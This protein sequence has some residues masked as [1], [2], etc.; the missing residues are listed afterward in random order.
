M[1]LRLETLGP[2][3]VRTLV[4]RVPSEKGNRF[5]IGLLGIT[6]NLKVKY[7]LSRLHT[8]STEPKTHTVGN[9]ER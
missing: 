9:Q 1:R 2:S 5:R 8:P 4:G 6:F 7:Y 3:A